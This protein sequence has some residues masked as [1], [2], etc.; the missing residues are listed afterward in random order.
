M[1]TKL[2]HAQ[3]HSKS[4]HSPKDKSAVVTCSCRLRIVLLPEVRGIKAKPN[5]ELRN[6]DQP[7][8]A[9]MHLSASTETRDSQQYE[10]A[11]SLLLEFSTLTGLVPPPERG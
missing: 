10:Y 4:S 11:S 7:I 9:T 2:F 3:Y 1:Q 5:K 8:A 6:R